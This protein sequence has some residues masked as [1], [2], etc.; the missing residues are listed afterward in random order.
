MENKMHTQLGDSALEML[1]DRSLTARLAHRDWKN[2]PQFITDEQVF[3]MYKRAEMAGN[4]ARVGLLS[5]E[6]GRR[7]LRHA[8]SY[9]YRTVVARMF[10]SLDQAAEE[11]SQYVWECL[12]TRPKDAAHAERRFGQLFLRR[13][14]DFQRRLLAKKRSMQSSLDA[15]AYADCDD[16]DTEDPDLTVRRVLALREEATPLDALERKQLA[17]HAASRL[18]DILT[19]KEHLAFV[20]LF[21]EEMKVKEVAAA[22][23]V[24]VRSINGYKNAALEKIEKEFKT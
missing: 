22:L 12:I 14:L 11:L 9:A 20:M 6:L 15:M 5:R 8:K 10:G 4:S 16:S 1:D 17:A 21:V 24:T 2:D 23:G 18:Q 3:R 7:L 19:K 13:S